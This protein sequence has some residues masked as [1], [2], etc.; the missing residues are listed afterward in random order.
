MTVLSAEQAGYPSGSLLDYH[1]NDF[2]PRIGMAYK[3]TAD[4]KT[5]IRAAYGLYG[6]AVYGTI[7]RNL[8]GGPFGG[9]ETFFNSITDGVPLLSFPNPFVPQAGQV[10]AFQS[11]SGFN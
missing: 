5:V 11:A 10:A 1:K 2:Y 9:S 8:E 3:L 6:N 7:A 4:G